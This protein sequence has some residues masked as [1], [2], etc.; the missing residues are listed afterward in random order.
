[1]YGYQLQIA[2]SYNNK[3]I[4]ILNNIFTINSNI[5]TITNNI[6]TNMIFYLNYNKEDDNNEN[7][8]INIINEI[9]PLWILSTMPLFFKLKNINQFLPIYLKSYLINNN[10]KYNNI[11]NT[12]IY[13]LLQYFYNK[14]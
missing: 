14:L 13:P 11:W 10:Y 3:L 4:T 5:L 8:N 6:N 7:I 12:N 1:M 2:I 9:N